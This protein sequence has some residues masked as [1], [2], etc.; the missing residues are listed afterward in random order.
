MSGGID[1]S[2]LLNDVL[3]RLS[4]E[5]IDVAQKQA[6]HVLGRTALSK[7]KNRND[8]LTKV[9][10]LK[11]EMSRSR[12]R[13]TREWDW[14]LRLDPPQPLSNEEHVELAKLVEIGLFAEERLL[15]SSRDSL[16]KTEVRELRH[17]Q[18]QGKRAFATLVKH[19]LRL[20]FNWARPY[21]DAVQPDEL[22]D[23]FQA[24]VI[25]LI[26]GLQGWDHRRG[27]T[28]STY[29]TNNIRQAIQRWRMNETL[30]IRVPVHVWPS[31]TS[32]GYLRRNVDSDDDFDEDFG[33]HDES[34][35]VEVVEND[36]PVSKDETSEN[37]G[38]AAAIRAF[39]IESYET[40]SRGI[41]DEFATIDA[42]DFQASITSRNLD[43]ML[44]S[45]SAR[46]AGVLRMR[47]GIG[48]GFPRTLDSIGEAYGVTRER[49][50]QIVEQAEGQLALI[51]L[52]WSYQSVTEFV[53]VVGYDVASPE[54]WDWLA[55]AYRAPIPLPRGANHVKT[56]MNLMRFV[57]RFNTHLA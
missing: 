55:D 50:R 43:L 38:L 4:D 45:L 48:D 13:K 24:G 21:R 33:N 47:Y 35:D 57:P 30:T 16:D 42:D 34:A 18:Q 20:V 52:M 5:G 7:N 14:Y 46:Q 3:G 36:E 29:V 32:A 12:K 51:L 31:L 25:G 22:Q 17:L 40:L 23:A 11:L 53:D 10:L 49:I 37:T 56:L 27:F 39:T 1:I 54:F 15:T 6:D 26:R 8:S 44:D 41:E 28:L 2:S 9:D 19:N